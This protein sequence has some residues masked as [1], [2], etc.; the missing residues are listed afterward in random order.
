MKQIYFFALIFFI[1]LSSFAATFSVNSQASFNAALSSAN[2]G[3][4]IEWVSGTYSNIFMNINE[5]DITVQ[6]ASIGEVIFNGTS[7]VEIIGNNVTFNGFQ[8]IGG[9]ILDG[10]TSTIPQTII[11]VDGSNVEISNINF[12]QY[13]CFKYL[14]I[15][16]SSQNTLV[17]FCNFENRINY[18]NQN[19][20]QIDVNESQPGFH[21]IQFCSFKNFSG[22]PGSTSGDDGVEPIRVGAKDQATRT[23]KT[24][25]EYCYFTECNGDD[26][27]ISGKATDCVYRYNT[28]ENNNGEIV[29]RHGDRGIVYGN[30]FVNN[31][32]GVRV[33]EGSN[34]IIYNNYFSGLTDK[35]IDLQASLDDLRVQNVTVAFN[36]FVNSNN[37]D[38]GDDDATN[39]PLNTVFI[40]NIFD[41]TTSSNHFTN[42]TGNE[43]WFGNIVDNEGDL[44]LNSSIG[45]TEVDPMLS[46]NSEGFYQLSA[47]SPAIDSAVD[48][49]AVFPLPLIT[50][51][52]YDNEI[53]LDF[54]L[55]N[56]PTATTSKDVGCQEYDASI[57]VIAHA[58][59]DNTGPVYLMP[60][61]DPTLSNVDF[62]TNLGSDVEV[63]PNPLTEA[64]KM[65]ISFNFDTS[66]TIQVELYN[67]SGQKIETLVNQS[68]DAGTNNLLLQPV[69]ASTG[70]YLLQ[71]NAKDNLG[72][73]KASKIEKFMK[74]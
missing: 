42:E 47:S 60:G 69:N 61:F 19:I 67:L 11:T 13:T 56:R 35:S 2:T 4:I 50:G 10:T 64:N 48:N 63:Y 70:M 27:V 26:E 15:R 5:S 21:T 40:N 8:Y 33:R 32:A 3:D 68:F 12:S 45:F 49:T 74:L 30:F 29:L 65:N 28:L 53:V 14:R 66:L 41:N 22:E 57:E 62:I 73:I 9:N 20:F 51:L 59:A 24:I 54:L 71:I 1:S 72:N 58:N 17:N 34:H 39:D 43:T 6:A 7:R 46:I 52:T 18:A 23:S 16:D 37:I 36:T 25:I 55:T 38:L 31:E 44:G